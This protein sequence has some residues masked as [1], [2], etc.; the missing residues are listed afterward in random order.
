MLQLFQKFSIIR[1]GKLKA[2]KPLEKGKNKTFQHF[3]HPLLLLLKN[4]ILSFY[5][6]EIL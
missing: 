1:F 2:E 4:T 6:E 3:K 5:R